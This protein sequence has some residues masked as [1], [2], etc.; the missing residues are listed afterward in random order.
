MTPHWPRY[1]QGQIQW[2]FTHGSVDT[3]I[4]SVWEAWH[5]VVIHENVSLTLQLR[6]ILSKSS[7][8]K[9][10]FSSVQAR[11]NFQAR[12]LGDF[13]DQVSSVARAWSHK[14]SS[15]AMH[16]YMGGSRFSLWIYHFGI[17]FKIIQLSFDM[18]R[19]SNPVHDIHQMI[20]GLHNLYKFQWFNE[21]LHL[22]FPTSN[23]GGSRP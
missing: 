22:A 23:I 21:P 9:C 18:Y 8:W 1:H 17:V 3:R 5:F 2:L 7:M 15:E 10:L 20:G 11:Q 6:S 16:V 14:F 12:A 13:H 19:V 4:G